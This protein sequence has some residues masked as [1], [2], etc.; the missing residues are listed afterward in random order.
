MKR[1][2][3]IGREEEYGN[4]IKY[5]TYNQDHIPWTSKFLGTIAE[6]VGDYPQDWQEVFEAA[7]DLETASTQY[8]HE[9]FDVDY[10]NLQRD[11][12]KAF[13]AGANWANDNK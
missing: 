8:V 4:V 1:F 12:K 3:F 10:I 5:S 6:C 2:K 11:I 9:Y 7:P 13:K